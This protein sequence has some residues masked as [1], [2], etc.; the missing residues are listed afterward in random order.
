MGLKNQLL[1]SNGGTCL[2][3]V[4]DLVLVLVNVKY[5]IKY[6]DDVFCKQRF[7][8]ANTLGE[9]NSKNRGI[10][11]GEKKVHKII[12]HFA[13]AAHEY[14]NVMEEHFLADN[15]NN[16]IHNFFHT[17]CSHSTQRIYWIIIIFQ[18]RKYKIIR[19]FI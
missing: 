6:A 3:I 1:R 13:V 15:S 2:N 14:S 16:I 11:T 9:I 19:A 17:L 8:K 18:H 4:Y 5:K 7:D 12:I 10:I